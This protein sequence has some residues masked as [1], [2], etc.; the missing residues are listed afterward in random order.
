MVESNI[1]P[2]SYKATF[3]PTLSIANDIFYEHCID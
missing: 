2:D 1:S 3:K